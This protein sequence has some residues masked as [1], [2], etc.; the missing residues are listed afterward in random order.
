MRSMEDRSLSG[1]H[2]QAWDGAKR[3][4]ARVFAFALVSGVGLALDFCLFLLLVEFGVRAGLANLISATAAVT[5]VYFASAR[6]IFAYEG[7]FLLGLFLL[8][9]GYQALAVSLA[10]W[11]VDALVLA[12]VHPALAKAAI[13]PLTFSANYLFMSFITRSRRA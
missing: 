8:Y 12:A 4:A 13:L 2:P 9:L 5:F 1:S 11:A 6:R 7:R 3:L 10:S